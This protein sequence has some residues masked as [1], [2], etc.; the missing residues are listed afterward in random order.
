MAKLTGKP[1]HEIEA[2]A[3]VPGLT[4]KDTPQVYNVKEG[5]VFSATLAELPRTRQ[6][7]EARRFL[8]LEL[9]T[10]IVDWFVACGCV[11]SVKRDAQLQLVWDS[12]IRDTRSGSR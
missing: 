2:G 1:L 8:A 12:V 3:V 4:S 10:R 5:R 11:S 9:S 7:A 6:I